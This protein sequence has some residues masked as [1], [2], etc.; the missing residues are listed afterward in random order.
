MKLILS[1]PVLVMAEAFNR[2]D[3]LKGMSAATAKVW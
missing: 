1:A 2:G 3:E